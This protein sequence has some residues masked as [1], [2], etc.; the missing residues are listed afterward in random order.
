MDMSRK[1]EWQS[2]E[3]GWG[4]SNNRLTMTLFILKN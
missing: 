3:P 4:R 2:N 1:P